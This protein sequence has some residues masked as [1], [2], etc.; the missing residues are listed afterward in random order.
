M[1]DFSRVETHLALGVALV[2]FL[3]MIVR[4]EYRAIKLENSQQQ[5]GQN[6]DTLRNQVESL[7]KT[8]AEQDRERD[9]K[10]QELDADVVILLARSEERARQVGLLKEAIRQLQVSEKKALRGIDTLNNDEITEF[11]RGLK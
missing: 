8:I 6:L 10:I 3:V 11:F 7:K 1:I 5:T 9:K 4:H 2:V